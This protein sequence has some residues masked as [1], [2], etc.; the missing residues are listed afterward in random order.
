MNRIVICQ[1]LFVRLCMTEREKLY[2]MRFFRIDEQK[3]LSETQ[4]N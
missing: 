1:T 2:L 3:C 4:S